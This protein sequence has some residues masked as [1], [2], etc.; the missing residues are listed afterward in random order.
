MI[1]RLME[2]AEE[3]NALQYGDFLLSDGQRTSYYFD[4]RRLSLHAE[5]A[6]LIGKEM[7]TLLA[8][9]G[10]AAVGGPTMGADPIVT[11]VAIASWQA[12][13]PLPAFIVR[14]E[15]KGYG[16]GQMIEGLLPETGSEVAVLDDTC[17]TGEAV[18]HSIDAV[19]RAGLRVAMVAV[20]MDRQSGGSAEVRRRGYRFESLLT[21]DAHG[22]MSSAR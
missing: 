1:D 22:R 20:L 11:A 16:M 12:G 18:L 19:E 17:N 3:L 2:L 13:C 5:G 10:V 4:G 14:N 8:N 7:L 6:H 15:A 9:T 21:L